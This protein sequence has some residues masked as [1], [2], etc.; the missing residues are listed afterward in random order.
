MYAKM[1]KKTYTNII[2][3]T[4]SGDMKKDI[5]DMTFTDDIEGEDDDR[6]FERH[7]RYLET[8]KGDT[9]LIIDNMD[10]SEEKEPFLSEML[11]YDCRLLFTSRYVWEDHVSMEISEMED[12]GDL[13]DLVITLYPGAALDPVPV[14]KIIERVHLHTLSVELAARLM[15]RG[16]L[17]PEELLA[18]L[19]EASSLSDTSDKIRIRKDGKV[20]KETY[21]EHI[22]ALFGLFSLNEHKQRY[23]G[24]LAMMPEK[25]IQ[26]RRFA[27]LAGYT[28]M[29]QVN[30]LIEMGLVH[31]NLGGRLLMHPLIR[32]CVYAD[33]KPDDTMCEQLCTTFVR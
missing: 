15:A 20:K 5:C 26:P 16:L 10:T 31:E 7:N 25:G 8:L 30:D 33:I 11:M 24:N 32:E 6:R 1:Y 23:L 21:R 13:M 9:L 17:S 18:R 3:L 14:K 28:D 19:E 4:Y 29:N 2:Y 27:D 12:Q 22:R